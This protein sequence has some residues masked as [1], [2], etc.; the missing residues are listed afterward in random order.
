MQ[1]KFKKI[2]NRQLSKLT[3]KEY[4]IALKKALAYNGNLEKKMKKR[5]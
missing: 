4:D 5:I 2:E 3:G 1:F